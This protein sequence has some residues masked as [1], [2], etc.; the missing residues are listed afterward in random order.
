MLK[1]LIMLSI[2]L[3][4]AFAKDRF[5]PADKKQF[6]DEIKQEIAEHKVEN[7]GKIDLQIIKPEFHSQLENY[8]EEEKFTREEMQRIKQRFEEY[9]K[10]PRNF[11]ENA[12]QAFYAFIEA[13]FNEINKKV[14]E[15]VKEGEVCNSWSCQEGLVCALD[16]NYVKSPSAPT[17]QPQAGASGM[18]QVLVD[19]EKNKGSC[20]L[21]NGKMVCE[22]IYRCYKPLS[23]GQS[24][25][26]NPVCG[27]GSCLPY[28]SMTSGIGE[29]IVEDNSCKKNSDC[30]SNL[31]HGGVCKENVVCK[32]CINN[33]Q[34]TQR[35]QK[36]CEGLY[37]NG[38]G[39]C[40]P[41]AP[42]LVLPQ[43]KIFPLKSILVGLVNLFISTAEAGSL[44]DIE[45]EYNQLVNGVIAPKT[46]D[47]ISWADGNVIRQA[48]GR[49]VYSE[50]GKPNETYVFDKNTGI[51]KLAKDIPS[52]RAD[53]MIRYG[54]DVLGTKSSYKE[55]QLLVSTILAKEG[56]SGES[57]K[58]NIG[59]GL[60]ISVIYGS[61]GKVE[62]V[63]TPDGKMS[64]ANFLDSNIYSA[65]TGSNPK[66]NSKATTSEGQKVLAKLKSTDGAEEDELLDIEA[67][68][69]TKSLSATIKNNEAKYKDGVFKGK[70]AA[71][72]VIAIKAPELKFPNVSNFKTCDIRFKDDFYNFLKNNYVKDAA[73]KST[74]TSYLDLH[75]AMLAFDFV[76]SGNSRNDYWTKNKNDA[77]SSIF[78]RLNKITEVSKDLRKETNYKINEIN[79]RLT[80]L[81]LDVQG[82]SKIPANKKEFFEKSCPDEYKLSMDKTEGLELD[83]ES[84]DGDA[85]GVKGKRLLAV[86]TSNLSSFNGILTYNNER[87]S[88]RINEVSRWAREDAKWTETREID[89]PLFRYSVK[90]G[91]NNLGVLGAI[92]GAL[93]AAG[94]IAILGGFATGSLLSA[95]GAAGI[96]AAS[97]ATGAGGLW[98]VASLKGAWITK[99][100]EIIDR[101]P[102]GYTCGKKQRCTQFT[103]VLRQPYNDICD[104]HTSANACVK[105]FVVINRAQQSRYLVDPWVPAGVPQNLILIEAGG[106]GN[107][108]RKLEQGFQEAKAAMISARPRSSIVSGSYRTD[109]FI[110][111]KMVGKYVPSLG[112]DLETLYKLNNEKIQTIKNAAMKFAV[113]EKFIEQ[114]DTENLK[115]FAE[116]AYEYHFVY[117][118]L[119]TKREISYPTV[120][121]NN[122]LDIM[123]NDIAGNMAAANKNAADVFRSLSIDHYKDYIN[124]LN[125]YKDLPINQ[126]DAIKTV[127]ISNELEKAQ[128]EL[129]NLMT[130][131]ALS[132][133]QS[134]DDQLLNMNAAF[135]SSNA[136]LAG[137]S[138]AVSFTPEQQNFLRSVGNLRK[139]RKTQ[140][141]ALAKYKEEM[142]A[143]GNIER[144]NNVANASKK[145]SQQF[146]T[147]NGAFTGIS[148]V[149]SSGFAESV[150][151]AS[152]S[153][154]RNDYDVGGTG[155]LYG[156][157]SGSGRVSS[158]G[159]SSGSNTDSSATVANEEDSKSLAEAIEARDRAN[160]DK[161]KGKDG[162]SLFEQV[163]NAYIRNYD[164]VLSK[165]KGKDV[166]EQKE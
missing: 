100:P 96:I 6:I 116:Y 102:R 60:N 144:A 26:A 29:C 104:V 140:L 13:Q 110:N 107:Y 65:I 159:A 91:G 83:R 54:V 112:E 125:L 28:D 31:C 156:S 57:E 136:N 77:S 137:A 10:D 20:K 59:F 35:G 24:C 115:K 73:G 50:S 71:A 43:V 148:P 76:L 147:G 21:I 3:N 138:G 62:S 86:W 87:V 75:M 142:A 162:L 66:R 81:C 124:T 27:A 121:L 44:G 22:E 123:A 42:P 11:G 165:K 34:K 95:W 48:N 12:E 47:S 166:V 23:L 120:G 72:D 68:K 93:L 14:L 58:V 134:L 79:N 88:S 8:F 52:L 154:E 67:S 90:G 78:G 133:N 32:D 17:P 55:N 101:D 108:A 111:E 33:G 161:Y 2:F 84:A 37:L 114:G 5:S 143:N 97:A 69:D 150:K 113:D 139:T 153:I 146:A 1:V 9:S 163:T 4:V 132:A 103:R 89:Y 109:V 82:V 41:D 40:V 131:N 85:S 74:A 118:K 105:N 94:V 30:C 45:R 119:S 70:S 141:K 128:K 53:W 106:P 64:V 135:I 15:K 61:D 16:P 46:G 80:C 129:D 56:K 151:P 117:P 127:A 130:L 122:Y 19:M 25:L 7:K 149:S 99:K 160:K 36:C 63:N 18:K 92:V 98:M 49:L 126:K 157:G 145:F 152:G 164:K 38:K 39:I 158:G 51:E 155:S